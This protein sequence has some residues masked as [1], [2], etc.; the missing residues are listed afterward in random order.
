MEVFTLSLIRKIRKLT[1][2]ATSD[3]SVDKHSLYQIDKF[4]IKR[5][6]FRMWNQPLF[7]LNCF[8]SLDYLSLQF[9]V[10]SI[11]AVQRILFRYQ[12]LQIFQI[13]WNTRTRRKMINT[14]IVKNTEYRPKKVRENKLSKLRIEFFNIL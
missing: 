9:F 4:A 8:Y 7:Y 6:L 3:N 1:G 12:W 5:I 11:F 2:M 13:L 14:K 10:I